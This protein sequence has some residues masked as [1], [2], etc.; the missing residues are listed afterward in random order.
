MSIEEARNV[1]EN[2]KA[3]NITNPEVRSQHAESA[4]AR[5]RNYEEQEKNA[6]G[7]GKCPRCGG[8]LVLRQ[9]IYGSFYGCSNYPNC[10]YTHPI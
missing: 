8:M 4:N 10:K 5:K 2:I 6:I 3:L 1:Y 9:G 7:H